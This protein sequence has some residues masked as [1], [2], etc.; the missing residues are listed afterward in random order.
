M[1]TLAAKDWYLRRG[2]RI[3]T[4]YTRQP[5]WR[6]LRLV[7]S[8]KRFVFLLSCTLLFPN[9]ASN[10]IYCFLPALFINLIFVS[11]TRTLE[12]SFVVIVNFDLLRQ[13]FARRV[14]L[15]TRNCT[16]WLRKGR[17]TGRQGRYS[18]NSWSIIRFLKLSVT[19]FNL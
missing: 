4:E 1:I 3:N 5:S 6:T 10:M 7:W 18:S 9:V 17:K 13:Y 14:I 8:R 19:F 11:L 2:M 12:N 15:F 16:H